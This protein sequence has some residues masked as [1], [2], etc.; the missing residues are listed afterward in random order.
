MLR[1]MDGQAVTRSCMPNSQAFGLAVLM[2]RTGLA[3]P[4]AH[5]VRLPPFA[6]VRHELERETVADR[7]HTGT[8]PGRRHASVRSA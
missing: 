3:P 5:P 2:A 7:C 4:A 8:K 6:Q 1:V